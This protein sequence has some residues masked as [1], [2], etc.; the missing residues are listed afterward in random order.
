MTEHT[1]QRMK[2]SMKALRELRKLQRLCREC[3]WPLKIDDI[4]REKELFLERTK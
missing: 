1:R 4:T 3:A 2:K